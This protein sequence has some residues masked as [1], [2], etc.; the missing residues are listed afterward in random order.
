M[1]ILYAIQGT[2]NGHVARSLE[3]IP[4][5]KKIGKVD[6]VLSGNQSDI[7]LP[8]EVKYRLHGASFIFGKKGGVDVRKTMQNINFINFIIEL[9]KI[10]LKNYDLILN[11]FEPVT[12]WA[13]KLKGI[14]CIGVSHQAAVLH[15]NA[16]KPESRSLLGRT[17][18][19]YYAPAEKNYGFHF[20]SLG[21]SCFTPVI[22]NE[23]R[24]LTPT[25]HNHYTVYL[26]AYKDE[27]II[28]FLVQFQDTKWHVFS[29]HTKKQYKVN[30]IHIQPVSN[31][32]FT[33]SLASS[34][35]VLC[36][37]GFET[38][39]E[40]LFLKKKLCVLPMKG[41]YEQQCN[42]SMLEELG[43]PVYKSLDSIPIDEFNN[44]LLFSKPVPV[45][46]IDDTDWIINSIVKAHTYNNVNTA[47]A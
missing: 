10:P 5:L 47:F 34:K 20:K 30:N 39:A 36:N 2:G 19:K 8:W 7:K 40:A 4:I 13:C 27:L 6:I 17:I 31:Q 32:P 16:P 46:Y 44:W 14:S 11:D 35:G 22:R 28:Q 29:K 9:N 41:Q 43:V 12:A 3:I 23:V 18:L 37:A 21:T 26:P 45:N 42:A 1:K 15:K 33:Q 38:P 25:Q 24:K